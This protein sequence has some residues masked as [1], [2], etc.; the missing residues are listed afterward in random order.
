M[1]LDITGGTYRDLDWWVNPTI[2]AG[3]TFTFTIGANSTCLILVVN[4]DAG[5]VDYIADHAAGFMGTHELT[6]P[7]GNWS[8]VAT[9][10]DWNTAWICGSGLETYTMQVD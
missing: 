6:I 4:I 8:E 9:V 10:S 2:N 7:A 3:G 1:F 5:T